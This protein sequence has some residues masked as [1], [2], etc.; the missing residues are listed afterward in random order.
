M[1]DTS[2]TPASLGNRTMRA[3]AMRNRQRLLAAAREIYAELGLHAG[4]EDI[5]RRAGL[6]M[7]TL[8]RHFPTKKD[9]LLTLR[10]EILADIAD[11]AAATAA[12]QP[13]GLG[14]E[15]CL[16]CICAG[17]QSHHRDRELLWQ[18]FPL[19]EDP[20]RPQFWAMI[21]T[22]LYEAQQAG[23]IRVDLTI[24]DAFLC[25]VSVRGLINATADR[26]PTAWRRHLA[27][28]LSGFRPGA[29]PLDYP[30]AS[31]SLMAASADVAPRGR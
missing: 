21:R 8:Y 1:P 5:A 18:A 14:F 27:L 16:W 25:I 4:V 20:G 7:G 31:E 17:I 11:R 23:H 10:Q 13:P 3:D 22:L 9:L 24:T 19:E 15:A 2:N 28:H 6:G 30:P 26:A 12:E 29:P